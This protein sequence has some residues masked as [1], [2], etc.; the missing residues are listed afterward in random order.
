MLAAHAGCEARSPAVTERAMRGELDFAE[1]LR[2]RVALLE[3]LDA[4]AL[5]TRCTTSSSSPRGPH[6]WCARSSGSA[7]A[8]RSSAA[9]S[10]SSP[11]GSPQTS[12]STSPVANELEVVDG[13][14][15]GRLVGDDR[16]PGRQGGRAAPVRR[17]VRCPGE[18]DDRDRR[19]RERPRHAQRRRTRHRVQRQ[20]RRAGGRPRVGERP[21]HGRVLYLLGISREEIVA[22]DAEAGITTP[23]PPV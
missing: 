12:A 7:T 21:L 13:R 19:R 3:G 9:G 17:R 20:A 18:R 22:A 15:T 16:R 6:H 11:T 4:S 1:S 5:W 23:A 8:S 14:L 10:P 2:D